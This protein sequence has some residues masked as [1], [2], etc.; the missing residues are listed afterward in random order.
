M[1]ITKISLVSG[2]MFAG[3]VLALFAGV[4]RAPAEPPAP[5]Q[6]QRDTTADGAGTL[7]RSLLNEKTLLKAL[8][9]PEIKRLEAEK[10]RLE[11]ERDA[12]AKKLA[13][14]PAAETAKA[15]ALPE[16]ELRRDVRR[17]EW[18]PSRLNRNRSPKLYF[19]GGTGGLRRRLSHRQW[20]GVEGEQDDCYGLADGARGNTHPHPRPARGVR[21]VTA[22]KLTADAVELE[23]EQLGGKGVMT[24][25]LK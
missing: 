10:A 6:P 16:I 4:D 11:A 9:A 2:R 17:R 21:R 1:R 19:L 5:P 14:A 24:V 7:L 18:R 12:L 13:A 3:L 23:V 8:A 20:H 22:K 15:T 25:T